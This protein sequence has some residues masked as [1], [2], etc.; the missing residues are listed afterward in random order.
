MLGIFPADEYGLF[1][2]PV[3]SFITGNGAVQTAIVSDPNRVALL[4][5]G[6]GTGTFFLVPHGAGVVPAS[7]KGL[8]LSNNYTRMELDYN[9]YGSLVQVQWDVFCNLGTTL[10][11]VSIALRRNPAMYGYKGVFHKPEATDSHASYH[12]PAPS[13]KRVV[14]PSNKAI[15]RFLREKRPDLFGEQ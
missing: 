6:D 9:S 1:D 2:A 10:T 7:G 3:A 13:R 5:S 12:L 15:L 14:V 8:F 4:F 11:V